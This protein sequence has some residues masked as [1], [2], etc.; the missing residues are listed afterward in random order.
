MKHYAPT[1]VNQ[2][3]KLLQ[4]WGGGGG[5]FRADVNEEMKLL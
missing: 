4:Q 2:A 1:D 5:G 3:F